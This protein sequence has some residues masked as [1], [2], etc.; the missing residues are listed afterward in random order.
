MKSLVR[1]ALE[2]G[3]TDTTVLLPNSLL[4]GGFSAANPTCVGTAFGARLIDYGKVVQGN[5]C[6]WEIPY[7]S[8]KANGVSPGCASVALRETATGKQTVPDVVFDNNSQ[9]VRIAIYSEAD[10]AAGAYRAIITGLNYGE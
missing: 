7:A 3:G 1:Y 4:S 9:V 8:L 10:I 2:N 5:T 6:T